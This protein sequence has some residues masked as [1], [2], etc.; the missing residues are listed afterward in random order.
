MLPLAPVPSV[1]EK[2]ECT[3]HNIKEEGRH[4]RAC[5]GQSKLCLLL[6][7]EGHHFVLVILKGRGPC[8][9]WHNGAERSTVR[10]WRLFLRQSK[11]MQ[12]FCYFGVSGHLGGQMRFLT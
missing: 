1:P 7:L 9:D 6:G 11:A 5:G 2:G 10:F 3:P 8:E 12:K 4:Y